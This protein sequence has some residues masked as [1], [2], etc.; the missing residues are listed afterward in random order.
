MSIEETKCVVVLVKEI[1]FVKTNNCIVF[2][3][4]FPV[5]I[6]RDLKVENMLL[7]GNMDLKL[8]G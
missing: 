4:I 8:I 1:L 2:I 3:C 5:F 7:D 6:Y